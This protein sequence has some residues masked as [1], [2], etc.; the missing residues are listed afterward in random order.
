MEWEVPL[1]VE[2]EEGVTLVR[3]CMLGSLLEMSFI[4]FQVMDLTSVDMLMMRWVSIRVV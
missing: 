3:D 4:T 1:L 2:K